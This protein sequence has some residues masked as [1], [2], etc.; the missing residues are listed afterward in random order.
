MG[1][2][3]AFGRQDLFPHTLT[4]TAL[5][6]VISHLFLSL[7]KQPTNQPIKYKPLDIADH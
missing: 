4:F 5:V 1:Q 7:K 2:K 3:T 6:A